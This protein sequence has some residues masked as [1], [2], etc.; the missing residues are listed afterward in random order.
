M[1]SQAKTKWGDREGRRRDILAAGTTI[2][3]RAGYVGLSMRAVADAAGVSPGTVYTYFDG[4]EDLF[5]VL[6]ADRLTAFRAEVADELASATDAEHALRLVMARYIDVYRVFGRE[7]D[8][9]AS[10]GDGLPGGSAGALVEVGLATIGDLRAALERLEPALAASPDIEL[11][12]PFLWSSMNGLAA[13]FTST[14]RLVHPYSQE[15]LIA[16]GARI[17]VAGIRDLL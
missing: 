7:F 16:V 4:K 10:D 9:W 12:V 1:A 13:H 11:I 15:Q 5:A 8:L 6:Y 3:A 2:L 14:R 17:I